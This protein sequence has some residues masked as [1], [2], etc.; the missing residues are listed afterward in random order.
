[1]VI[2]KDNVNQIWHD[3]FMTDAFEV[4]KRL[5]LLSTLR[6]TRAVSFATPLSR[7]RRMVLGTVRENTI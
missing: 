3:W 7:R 2:N 1:M 4:E 6:M 5:W